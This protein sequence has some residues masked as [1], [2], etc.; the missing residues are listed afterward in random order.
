[1]ATGLPLIGTC[2][3]LKNIKV[4]KG[5]SLLLHFFQ[6]HSHFMCDFVDLGMH[7]AK[8][9]KYEQ[10]L[11]ILFDNTDLIL[12]YRNLTIKNTLKHVLLDTN[13]SESETSK[14][15]GNPVNWVPA[16]FYKW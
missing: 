11:D 6:S 4:M 8:K 15:G 7:G 13:C 14:A 2:F 9:S 5:V 12:C 1:M 16:L 10:L 3:T